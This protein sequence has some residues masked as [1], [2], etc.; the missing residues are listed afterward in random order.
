V[1]LLIKD[2]EV[3]RLARRLAELTGETPAAAVRRAPIER[4]QREAPTQ[5]DPQ[6]IERLREISDRCAARPVRDSRSDN[7]LAGYR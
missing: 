1:T 2:P 4:L 5:T 7:E 6:W 3:C